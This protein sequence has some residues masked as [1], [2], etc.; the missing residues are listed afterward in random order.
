VEFIEPAEARAAF[1]KLAYTQ[2][3]GMPL[4]LEWAPLD[5]FKSKADGKLPGDPTE[6]QIPDKEKRE[7]STETNQKRPPPV[8]VL[9]KEEEAEDAELDMIPEPD[10]TLFVKNL[11]FNTL[12]QA[13]K[14]ASIHFDCLKIKFSK[15]LA[16]Q[17][18]F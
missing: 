11:N 1:K 15:S 17:L 3:R 18:T 8:T 7:E 13:L 12:D 6:S 9:S 16:Y 5:T 2:F 14:T 4:Y 10:T